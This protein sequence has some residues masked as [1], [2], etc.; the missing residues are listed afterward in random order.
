MGLARIFVFLF[1]MER[2]SEEHRGYAVN[3][4]F[5]VR[6]AVDVGKTGDHGPLI[7][8]GKKV[9]GI[10]RVPSFEMLGFLASAQPTALDSDSVFLR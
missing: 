4:R 5:S 7:I 6:L 3:N 10:L 1:L 2:E 9:K 8:R